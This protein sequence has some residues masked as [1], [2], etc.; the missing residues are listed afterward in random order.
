MSNTPSTGRRL[1]REQT[2][3]ELSG[4]A[5]VGA[6]SSWCEERWQRSS[7]SLTC[8]CIRKR[9]CRFATLVH[10]PE[11]NS[12]IATE[13]RSSLDVLSAVIRTI[14]AN[15]INRDALRAPHKTQRLGVERIA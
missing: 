11:S 9:Q 7:S 4:E 14:L 10:I 2:P 13:R 1:R 15:G 6:A 5:A 8:I 12:D 3:R